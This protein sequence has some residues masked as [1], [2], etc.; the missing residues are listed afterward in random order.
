MAYLDLTILRLHRA[1]L[2][3]STLS[4]YSSGLRAYH[5][6][7]SQV[8]LPLLPLHEVNLER[9]VSSLVCRVGYRCIKVY[10]AGVQFYS[11]MSGF[12]CR[13][14]SFPRLYYLLRGVRRT[15]GSRFRRPARIPVTLSLLQLIHHRLQ[16][17]SYTPTARLMLRS[18]SSLA[19][20]GLLRVSEYTSSG[21]WSFNAS[22]TLLVSNVSF[23]GSY[24]IMYIRIKASKTD[25]FKEGCTIRVAA[26]DSPLCPVLLMREYLRCHPFGSGPLF[27]WSRGCYLVRADIVTCL[28]RCFP[29]AHNINTHSFRIGGASA[30]ASAGIPDSQIQILGRWSSDAYRRYLRLSDSSVRDLSM[31]L[32]SEHRNSRVWDSGLCASLPFR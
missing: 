21:R 13:I 22:S 14:A 12:N 18:A 32:A 23:D 17:Q 3:P 25:P 2:A 26:V 27:T 5:C 11:I 24:S 4:T 20:F 1:A 30:A 31:A 28:R 8:S 29:G 9:F 7:C 6:F 19:F 15:Q 10:L 16:L